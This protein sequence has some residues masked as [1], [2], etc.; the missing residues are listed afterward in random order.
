MKAGLMLRP[1]DVV[2]S[3]YDYNWWWSYGSPETDQRPLTVERVEIAPD[4]RSLRARVRGLR[5]GMMTRIALAGVR[6]AS[7]APLLHPQ[8]DY[9]LNQFPDGPLGTKLIAKEVAPPPTREELN[10]GWVYFN[11]LDIYELW[12]GPGWRLRNVVLDG[13][14][15][16]LFSL[17]SGWGA[18]VN[19]QEE[20]KPAEDLRS[21]WIHGSG[22]V[23][24]EFVM[25]KKARSQA[26]VLG[27][28]GIE[29]RDDP[30]CGA[31]VGGRPPLAKVGK[32]AGEWQT[33]DVAFEAAEFDDRGRKVKNA[34]FKE[35]K[36]NDV[37]IHRDVELPGTTPGSFFQDESPV[38][39]IV[40]Q[41]TASPIGFRQMRVRPRLPAPDA[42]GWQVLRPGSRRDWFREGRARWRVD[43][44][45]VLTARG[46]AGA[47]VTQRGGY[48]NFELRARVRINHRGRGG[49]VLRRRPGGT[50]GYE[51]AI[52]ASRDG[53]PRTGSIVGR[54]DLETAV[55]RVDTWGA[56]HVVCRDE[57]TATRVVVSINGIRMLDVRDPEGSGGT[58]HIGIVSHG[59]GTVLDVRDLSIRSL[60]E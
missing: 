6:D 33:L 54:R 1:K 41:G 47:L 59:D 40:L 13:Q 20:K 7:G 43:R 57:G 22:D 2:V 28:Y 60:P 51:I 49:L 38:G 14:D 42:E 37:V 53:A 26:W 23:H 46:G 12:K 9:T 39:P 21:R 36:L 17:S 34:R 31:I 27:C 25:P 52:N 5:Q 58:G 18:Y 4:R 50:A 35:V 3:Q 29:L 15:P 45:G 11:S 48:G 19:M 8:A 16:M 10:E 55:V 30:S 56:L 44:G 32:K 24:L